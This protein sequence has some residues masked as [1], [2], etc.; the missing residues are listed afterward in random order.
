M[1]RPAGCCWALSSSSFSIL[2]TLRR[3]L[4]KS[5]PRLVSCTLLACRAAPGSQVR[6]LHR[7]LLSSCGRGPNAPA[8]VCW[9][10]GWPAAAGDGEQDASGCTSL[11]MHQ[12]GSAANSW[13]QNGL[14]ALILCFLL[15]TLKVLPFRPICDCSSSLKK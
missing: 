5:R 15:P 10:A 11:F 1:H 7:Q 8:A 6:V 14:K 13:P 9:A 12:Q 2:L 3:L 4:C